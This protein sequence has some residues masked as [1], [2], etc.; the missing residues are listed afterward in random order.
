MHMGRAHETSSKVPRYER[1]CAFCVSIVGWVVTGQ[2]VE[3][4]GDRPQFPQRS[5][6]RETNST[7]Q[8]LSGDREERNGD[9]EDEVAQDPARRSTARSYCT[10]STKDSNM[11]IIR[12]MSASQLS[13]C[14]RFTPHQ[15]PH[16]HSRY[17][18]YENG[19]ACKPNSVSRK[20][21]H[22]SR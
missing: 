18:Q 3:A 9:I 8:K 13:F 22:H 20:E 6:I 12:L 11:N 19:S 4:G 10:P 15:S 5:I 7:H 16:P 21:G 1:L 17:L 14:A 2:L